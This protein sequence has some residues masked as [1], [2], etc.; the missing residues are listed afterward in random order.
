MTAGACLISIWDLYFQYSEADRVKW[1]I[2]EKSSGLGFKLKHAAEW[3][4]RGGYDVAAAW[5]RDGAT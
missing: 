2:S 4:F 3:L 5:S 1:Q